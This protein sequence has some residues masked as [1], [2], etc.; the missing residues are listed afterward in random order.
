LARESARTTTTSKTEED[1]M[2]SVTMVLF[3]DGRGAA[4]DALSSILGQIVRSRAGRYAVAEV[5]VQDRPSLAAHYNV[6]ATPTIL[7][8]KNG[9][10]VDRIV[11]TPTRILLHNLLEE[12]TAGDT[13]SGARRRPVVP[14]AGEQYNRRAV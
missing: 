1:M 5:D 3:R 7:L 6:R 13:T 12:R 2:A 14:S 10:V 4:N 8:M 11:G 9:T